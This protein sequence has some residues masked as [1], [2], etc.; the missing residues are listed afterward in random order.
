VSLAP[1]V[2]SIRGR[3]FA[4]IAC[5]ATVFGTGT[6][7]YWLLGWYAD[8]KW[9]LGDCA[10]MTIVTVTTVGYQEILP[11]AEVTGGRL[12]TSVLIFAGL[13]T[14][15]YAAS[16][17]T[18][19]LVEG[20]F[21]HL[22]TRRKMKKMI[23]G[24]SEHII[25]CGAGAHGAAVVEELVATR[26]PAVAIDQDPARLEHMRELMGTD[27]P[28][29]VGDATE[30]ATLQE[31]GIE[32]ARGVIATLPEDG[33]NLLIIVTARSLNARIKIVAKA[34]KTKSAEKL[35]KAGA[36]SVVTPSYIG[37]VRMV[38]E[39]IRPRAIEF[40]DLMVRDRE[41]NLRI[42]EVTLPTG[43]RLHGKPLGEAR[44]RD[45]T[46]LL[47]IAVREPSGKFVYNP[48]PGFQLTEGMS[49]IVLG[50][51][52][53]VHLLRGAA[54]RGFDPTMSVPAQKPER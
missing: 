5:F 52:D 35:R 13:G 43:S 31:A 14:A 47:V 25:V 34:E 42:E 11:V 27:V 28:A 19:F 6:G 38:S 48:G 41:R 51:T 4:A 9:P 39:M 49:L 45:K 24:L 20:E 2:A 16:A 46:N 18:T 7:G 21:Q 29:I 26:W 8:K 36:D 22:R 30:D 33:D 12:F 10:Y 37:G 54:E 17:L 1:P 15:L 23:D 50:E 44:I 3:L 53:A 32:R 40:L